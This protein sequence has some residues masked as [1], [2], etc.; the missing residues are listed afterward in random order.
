M[1]S[2]LLDDY[3]QTGVVSPGLQ[4]ALD[5]FKSKLP[6][7]QPPIGGTPAQASPGITPTPTTQGPGLIPTP[8]TTVQSAAPPAPAEKP[9]AQPSPEQVEL[10]RI[11]NPQSPESKSGIQQIKNPWLRIPLTVLDAIGT[12]FAPRLTSAIPG[13]QLHHA[14]LVEGLENRLNQEQKR[15]SEQAQATAQQSE[16]PLREAQTAEA[17]AHAESLRHPQPKQEEA[18]KTVETDQG[19]M[20]WNPDTQRYDIR[21]G[22]G[23]APKEAGTVHQL[24]DGTL[25]MAHPDGTATAITING[26]PAKGKVTEPKQTLE[27]QAVAEDKKAHPGESTTDALAHIKRATEKP[28][29]EPGVWSL[30]QDKNGDF[31]LFNNKTSEVKPAG[32]LAKFSGQAQSRQA[33]GEVIKQAGDALIASIEKHRDKLGNLGSYWNQAINGT[34]IA[35]KDVSGLMAQISSFAALQPALHGFRGQQA[36]GEFS[37]IIGGVPKNPDALEAAIRAIQGTAQIVAHPGAGANEA[38]PGGITLEDIDKE[39]QRRK[40]QKQ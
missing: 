19:I 4:R 26:Q 3:D 31:V 10:N 15:E 29:A 33:Q 30:Q 8:L 7:I 28:A 2:P 38:L 22:G 32:D 17:N 5:I 39:I 9:A 11:T 20:Q 35:D 24:E 34:P 21:V 37:K 13:T 16:I 25:I 1:A 14:G 40:G 36:M 27:E 18:G 12:G 23:K 6:Q